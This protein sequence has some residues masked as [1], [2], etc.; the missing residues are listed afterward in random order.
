MKPFRD[1]QIVFYVKAQKEK[2]S[3]LVL[4]CLAKSVV[5]LTIVRSTIS[6]V[7]N[8]TSQSTLEI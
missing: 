7:I 3:S 2:K 4:W 5:I 6:K 1:K 8:L